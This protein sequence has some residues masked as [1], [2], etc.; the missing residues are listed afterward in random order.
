MKRKHRE[1]GWVSQNTWPIRSWFFWRLCEA[2]K[3]DFRRENGWRTLSGPFFNGNGH[4]E[5]LCQRCAPSLEAVEE[6][7]A[8]RYEAKLRPQ[9]FTGMVPAPHLPSAAPH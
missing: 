3:L 1:L 4:W 9:A 2:C 5:Y 6:F 7:Y 8:R